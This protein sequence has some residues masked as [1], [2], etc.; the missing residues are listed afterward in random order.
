MLTIQPLNINQYTAPTFKCSFIFY[1]GYGSH[2][3][4]YLQ[5]YQSINYTWSPAYM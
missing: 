3:Y 1:T 5:F 4:S 2:M